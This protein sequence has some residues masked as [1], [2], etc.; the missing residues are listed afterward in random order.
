[1]EASSRFHAGDF[2]RRIELEGTII[3]EFGETSLEVGMNLANFTAAGGRRVFDWKKWAN[4]ACRPRGTPAA[5]TVLAGC[6]SR[7]APV[8]G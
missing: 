7:P 4:G 2:G 3:A 5:G 8:S 1:M 6:E